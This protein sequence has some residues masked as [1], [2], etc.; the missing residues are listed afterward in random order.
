MIQNRDQC[1]HQYALG[2]DKRPARELYLLAQDPHQVN[3]VAA[4]PK[5][6]EL[7]ESL[8]QRLLKHL[9]EAEDPRVLSD[10]PIFER[11]PFTAAFQRR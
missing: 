6:Q 10:D 8:H 5:H 4:E 2:F 3:N 11:P 9:R 7:V 1:Q